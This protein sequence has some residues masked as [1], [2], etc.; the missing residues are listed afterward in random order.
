[1][2]ENYLDDNIGAPFANVLENNSELGS[3]RVPEIFLESV[4]LSQRH[5]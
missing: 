3:S 2:L 4:R 5:S 1:M